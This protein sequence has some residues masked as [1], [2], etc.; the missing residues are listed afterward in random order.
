MAVT[1]WERAFSLGARAAAYDPERSISAQ[2]QSRRLTMPGAMAC[3]SPVRKAIV[4][5]TNLLTDLIQKTCGAQHR[6]GGGFNG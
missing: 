6:R 3:P 2:P 1:G 4:F 5:G